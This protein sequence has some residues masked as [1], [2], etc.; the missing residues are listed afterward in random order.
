MFPTNPL[1]HFPGKKEWQILSLLYDNKRIT[2]QTQKVYADEEYFHFV[3][4]IWCKL[5]LIS[6]ENGISFE[7]GNRKIRVYKMELSGFVDVEK[8]VFK[9]NE[10]I[11][12]WKK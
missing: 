9:Y 6:C 3:M 2:F 8:F 4:K 1:L 11:K 12:E 7:N 5:G 10:L